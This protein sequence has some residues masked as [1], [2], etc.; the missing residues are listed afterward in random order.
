LGTRIVPYEA[1][2]VPKVKA[3]NARLASGKSRWHFYDTHVPQWLPKDATRD[4]PVWRL[5]YLAID[6]EGE[7]RGG[8]CFKDQLFLVDGKE[9]MIGSWQGPVSEGL[10][11]KRYRQVGLQCLMHMR[12]CNPL[13]L[14]WGGS[15]RLN[16]LLESLGWTSFGMPLLLRLIRPAR[17]LR[18]APF[19]RQGRKRHLADI[20]SVTG[21]GAAGFATV[22][23]GIAFRA[24]RTRPVSYEYAERFGEWSDRIWEA[25]KDHYGCIA[26]RTADAL[27]LLMGRPGWPDARIMRVHDG[28]KTIGWA[29]I[30]VNQMRDDVRFGSLKVGSVIDALSM[31]GA[32]A[33]VAATATHALTQ[34]AVDI[35]AGN[36]THPRWVEAFKRS[37]YLVFPSRRTLLISRDLEDL[38][39]PVPGDF[40]AGLHL[41]PIDA[42]GP[43]G[44]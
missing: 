15:D 31:P 28:D 44:L 40:A 3:M 7:V 8:F 25:A 14:C 19:L 29:A 9:T 22:Q 26:V 16:A 32:E 37:G 11:D 43:L 39:G 41:A 24:G 5:S 12:D 20:A 27:D 35:I 4:Q 2:H 17:V 10:I 23:A 36:Y 30:R 18:Q 13:M 1:A 6:D 34:E 42:D 21:I 38:V 33:K